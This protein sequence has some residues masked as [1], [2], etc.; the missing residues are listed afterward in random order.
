MANIAELN[1][2]QRGSRNFL[3][4]R[5]TADGAEV[6]TIEQL[7]DYHQ[8]NLLDSELKNRAFIRDTVVVIH[9]EKPYDVHSL[10]A[11]IQAFHPDFAAL[12]MDYDWFGLTTTTTTSTTTTSTT[13]TTT[14]TTTT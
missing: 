7:A 1:W 12:T 4:V 11:A 8:L 3:N 10:L 13:T 9:A 14:T 2:I 5:K 6:F